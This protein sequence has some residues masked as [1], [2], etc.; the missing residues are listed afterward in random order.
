VLNVKIT[1]QLVFQLIM[2]QIVNTDSS[3]KSLLKTVLLVHLH[4]LTVLQL[5][6]SKHVL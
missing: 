3:K 4:Q 1:L 6:I 2:E 5:L